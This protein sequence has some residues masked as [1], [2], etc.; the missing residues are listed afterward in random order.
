MLVLEP[1][2][3]PATKEPT[4]APLG[5]TGTALRIDGVSKS[6]R[7]GSQVLH[8]LR[9]VSFAMEAGEVLSVIGM[10][11]AGKTTLL[12]IAAGME[13]ADAGAVR[14]AGTELTAL[15]DGELSGLLGGQIAWAGKSGPGM[16][17]RL[18]DYVAMP[19]LAGRAAGK[20]GDRRARRQQGQGVYARAWAALERVGAQECAEAQWAQISDWERALVEI[21]QGIAGNPDLLLIDD[22]TDTLGIRE[23]DELGALLRSLA[24]EAG[25]GILMSVSDAQA[26]LWSDRIMTL[27]G[28]RLAEGPRA[29]AAN[30]IEL[31]D[32]AARREIQRGGIQ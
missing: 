31:P 19:L 18:L 1:E 13:S 26:T 27:A 9:E 10:R 30:V 2:A 29:S 14:F 7:R 22:L 17:M 5:A 16:R 23:T 24:Q 12:E 21:A 11:A 25:M 8:V 20:R 15:S 32:L 4:A 6:Y 3:P 28:G